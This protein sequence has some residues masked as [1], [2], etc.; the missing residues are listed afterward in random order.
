MRNIE[1]FF[2][3]CAGVDKATLAQ[4]TT[5]RNKYVGIGATVFFTGVL[6][7]F[8][9]GYALYTV[10]DNVGFALLFG[11]IWGT[12]IFNLDRYIVMSMK[13]HSHWAHNFGMALPRLFL[14]GL[15][16]IVISKPLEMRIF[17]KEIRAEIVQ[18]EQEVFKRQEDQV[19]LRYTAQI[20]ALQTEITN[21]NA[22]IAQKTATRDTLSLR[23]VQEADGTG[24]SM[25]R[26]LGPIY[27][28]KKA[29]ADR[30]EAALVALLQSAR[31]AIAEKEA[32]VA[33]LRQQIQT[34]INGLDRARYDGMAARME[35]LSRLASSSKAIW[36][37][38]LFITLL[39]VA[40]E[41]APIFVKLIA[42]RSPYDHLLHRHEH[43]FE[44]EAKE[45]ITLRADRV[46][47]KLYYETQTGMHRV[48][49]QVT[50]EKAAID[51]QLAKHLARLKSGLDVDWKP[52]Y[53][54]S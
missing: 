26:N 39:F 38:S 21:L 8:S 54:R 18:M 24:G 30:A 5:D 23:A 19:K 25:Q 36:L 28:A 40:I 43:V 51:Q 22:E 44:M 48:N 29:E 16:A 42:S 17:E 47:N 4:C 9:G 45:E 49:A 13:S 7:F 53:P 46:K 2:L 1:E 32:A 6:A 35:A 52:E 3:Y 27:Q 14:A 41:T 15:L 50:A 10:F 33:T 31:P 34:E 37:A 12:M 20:E 11:L